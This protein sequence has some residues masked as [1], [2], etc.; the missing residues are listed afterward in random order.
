MIMSAIRLNKLPLTFLIFAMLLAIC[1][2]YDLGVQLTRG[3]FNHRP[4]FD[5]NSTEAQLPSLAKIHYNGQT[6]NG[7]I[8][9]TVKKQPFEGSY[10]IELVMPIDAMTR[11]IRAISSYRRISL[12]G[13]QVSPSSGMQ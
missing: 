7:R 13:A 4:L 9:F 10:H 11:T 2:T 3:Q 8:L 6:I 1:S 5:Q 12:R